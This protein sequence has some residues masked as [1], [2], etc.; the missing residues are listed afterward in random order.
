[1]GLFNKLFPKKPT[2]KEFAK[3]V[4]GALEKGGASGL[5]YTRLTLPCASS[6]QTISSTTILTRTIATQRRR[7]SGGDCALCIVLFEYS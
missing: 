2:K 5:K 6:S 3:I 4:Q 7:A 1:M